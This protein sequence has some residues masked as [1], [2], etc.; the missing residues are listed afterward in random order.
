MI[1]TLP[2][3]AAGV[4]AGAIMLLFSHVAPYIGAGNF[5]RDL[6]EPRLFGREITHREG[7]IVGMLVHLLVSAVWGGGY[8]VLVAYGVVEGYT[9]IPIFA[10]GVVLFVVMGGIVLPIEG[11]GLF[12]LKEDNWFPIDIGITTVCWSVLF[13]WLM[14]I[15]IGLGALS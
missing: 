4:S 1:A 14:H 7:H 12:G 15:W 6:D 13:W 9:L 2:A 5:I 8:A 11:H 10:W 3:I